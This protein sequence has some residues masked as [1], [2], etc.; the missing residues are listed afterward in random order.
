MTGLIF[1]ESGEDLAAAFDNALAA[2]AMQRNDPDK[3]TFWG[4]FEYMAHDGETGQDVFFNALAGLFVR[5]P[6]TEV[7]T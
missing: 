5:V 4:R 2:G 1:P 3:T 6:R 7:S